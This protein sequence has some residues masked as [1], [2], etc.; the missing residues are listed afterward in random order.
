MQNYTP[1]FFIAANCCLIPLFFTGVGYVLGRGY[2][3][4]I[5]IPDQP[6]NLIDGV[7]YDESI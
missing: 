7:N 2:R 6:P 4:K 1:L 5:S 3:L